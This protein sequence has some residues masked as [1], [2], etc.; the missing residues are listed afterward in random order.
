MPQTY[1]DPETARNRRPLA[2]LFAFLVIAGVIFAPL[3]LRGPL[4]RGAGEFLTVVLTVAILLVV[5][6]Y[7]H[8]YLGI[9]LEIRLD[10][11]GNCELETRRRTIRVP[12]RDIHAVR[13][14]PENDN[15]PESYEIRFNGGKL[16]VTHTM[17]D[18]I[19]FLRRLKSFN[20]TLDL[21]RFP[22]VAES[23]LGEAANASRRIETGHVLRSLAFPAA[24]VILLIWLSLQTVR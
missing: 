12:A 11:H 18:F 1:R 4:S 6:G 3:L 21:I 13:Y 14:S 17:T 19:D 9:C 23:V 7:R 10:D 15:G 2:G 5:G 16:H 8:Q 24:V 20:P 22:A